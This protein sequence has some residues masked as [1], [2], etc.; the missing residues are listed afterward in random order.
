MLSLELILGLLIATALPLI[1][2]W[3]IY[4]R[5]LY[6]SGDMLT[7]LQC[8]AWG[9]AAFVLAF[10]FHISLIRFAGI[11]ALE[12]RQV[13]APISEEI[14][15]A[16]ILVWLVRRPKFTYFVDGAIYGF[17]VGIGFAILENYDYILGQQTAALS[18]AIGRTLSSNLMHAAASALVGVS[19]GLSRFQ[20]GARR[21]LFLCGGLL[22]AISMHAGFNNLL[23]LLDRAGM[24]LWLSYLAAMSLG[25]VGVALVLA[26]IWY[27]LREESAWIQET[28]GSADRITQGEARAVQNLAEAGVMLSPIAE[29]FGAEKATLVSSFLVKQARLGILR[30]TLE[31]LPDEELRQGARSQMSDLHAEM[32]GLRRKVG[33]YPMLYLRSIYTEENHSVWDRLEKAVVV[34]EEQPSSIGVASLLEGLSPLQRDIMRILLHK[35]RRVSYTDLYIELVNRSPQAIPPEADVEQALGELVAAKRLE[36][37][38]DDSGAYALNLKRKDGLKLTQGI[39]ERLGSLTLAPSA[40]GGI[41]AWQALK[42][43]LEEQAAAHPSAQ[44]AN[45]WESLAQRIPVQA[46]VALPQKGNAALP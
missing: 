19:L 25:L 45:L 30:K 22:I 36:R 15:K 44:A 27:G 13:I 43:S 40:G 33:A 5:D 26:L 12:V 41:D 9:A 3:L 8:F 23:L 38:Q 31:K 29:R 1:F 6:A 24:E 10:V 7:V 46:D 35:R 4:T 17:A 21:W 32:D 20:R 42:T 2:L 16:L 37:P 18:V 28:L 34:E 11:G 39:W 14:F